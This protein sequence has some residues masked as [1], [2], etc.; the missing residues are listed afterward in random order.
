MSTQLDSRIFVFPMRPGQAYHP[1]IRL[2]PRRHIMPGVMNLLLS[3]RQAIALLPAAL[4]AAARRLP[5]NKIVK[6]SLGSNLWNYFPHVPFTDTLDVM[7]DT[8]FI[9]L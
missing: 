1:V 6:W 9:G 8:G 3:R 7:K 5:V 2:R 4:A